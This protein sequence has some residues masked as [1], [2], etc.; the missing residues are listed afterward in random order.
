LKLAGLQGDAPGY[1]ELAAWAKE[2]T[3]KDAVFLVP[4]DEESFRVHARRAIVVNF[5]GVPQLSAELPAWRDRLRNVLGL[6]TKGLL[7]LPKPMGRTLMAIRARYDALP[8]AHHGRVAA[9]Y[10]ARFVILCHPVDA[11]GFRLAHSDSTGSYFL[12]DLSPEPTTGTR[13]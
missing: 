11:P 7:D 12:Y 5:K 2:N 6:D 4:P 8:P 10:G 3:P 13:P 9:R 1:K